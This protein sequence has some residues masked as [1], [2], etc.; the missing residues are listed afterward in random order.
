[1]KNKIAIIWAGPGGLSAAML[2]SSQGH[3]VDIYEK[4]EAIWGRNS[5]LTLAGK[6]HFDVGPTFLLMK[7]FLDEIFELSWKKSSDYLDFKQVDP[8]Y[9]LHFANVSVS[10]TS[11]HKKMRETIAQLF[12][13]EEAWFDKYLT[14]EDKRLDRKSVV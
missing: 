1:M 2:L 9:E 8:M 6:Y 7:P 5:R 14:Y 12:P 13:G 4:S 10:M 3:E 11:D